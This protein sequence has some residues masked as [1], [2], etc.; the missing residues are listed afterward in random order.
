M[1]LSDIQL[2]DVRTDTKIALKEIKREKGLLV[3]FSCNTC[4]FVVGTPDFPGWERQYN[5]LYEKAK[6]N[7]IG[8]VLINSN[9]G[10]RGKDDSYTEMKN[11][12]EDKGYK[13]PYLLDENSKLANEFEAKTTPHVYLFDGEMKLVYSGSVDN[14]WD[15]KRI[16]ETPYLVN[17]MNAL[18][19][20]KKIKP[21]ETPPR[22]CS[23]KRIVKS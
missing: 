11:H 19:Q 9:E 15:N 7:G 23:I 8:M 5:D 18:N 16:E 2:T 21:S 6:Q 22:G 20:G 1:P 17:A 10:K 14:I 13:M 3:I 4:P 12:A